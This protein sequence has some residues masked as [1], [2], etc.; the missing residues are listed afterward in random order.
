METEKDTTQEETVYF[1]D[2]DL[3]DEV[4]DALY[5]MRFEKCTPVQAKC[6]PPLLEG[7]DVIG[8]AQTGTGKTAAYLLP[9]LT[10]LRRENHPADAVNCLIMAPTRELARQIDQALQGFSYYL[11]ING[12]AVYGGN[13][14]TRYEQE[15]RSLSAGADIVIATPGRLI[16]HLSLG[17]LDLSRTTH[18]ILDEADRMLDMGF[19]EDILTIAAAMPKERQTILFSA[20]FD[21][22]MLI[23]WGSRM[24]DVA[25]CSMRGGMVAEKRMVCRSFGMAAAMVRISSENP[26][27]SIR[28]ASSRMRC[29]VRL[30]SSVPRLRCVIRRPGVAITM[31]AP[32]ERLRRS[33]S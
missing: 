3:S 12:V 11:D 14:G 2:L 32:A 27:S 30:R 6:I 21:T 1:E 7:R 16:T 18:L 9:M 20:G 17:T 25:S 13:D 22:A 29:V 5:D 8:I 26:M 31:S 19:S 24:I 10:L 28:S 33:C 4:L 23:C 15:R